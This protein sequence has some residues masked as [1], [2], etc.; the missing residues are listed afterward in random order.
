VRYSL[1]HIASGLLLLAF[2]AGGCNKAKKL[3]ERVTLWRK[4]KIPY[5][6]FYAHENLKRI[7][8]EA[9]I[10]DSRRSPD[11]SQKLTIGSTGEYSGRR[12]SYVVISTKVLANEEELSAM[13]RMVTRGDQVFISSSNISD[14]LLDSLQLKAALYTG[15]FSEH[16]S[17]EVAVRNPETSVQ[18]K[19]FYPG[20]AMDNYFSAVDSTITTVLGTDDQGR[21]NFIK[22]SYEGGGAF[23]IHLAPLALSNFFLLHKDNKSYYDQVLSYLPKNTEVIRWDDYFRSSDGN[24]S[25]NDNSSNFSALSWWGKQQGLGAAMWLLLLLLIIIYLVESKRKQRIIPVIPALNNAS[26]DFVKTIGQLYFQRKDNKDLAYK[27]MVHFQGYV[28]NRYAIRGAAMDDE[29]VQRLAYKSGYDKE[30]IQALVYDLHYAQAQP[31]ITDHALLELNHKLET[32]YKH[33]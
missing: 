7:F 28:R 21:A 8:P 3:N 20:K 17:L 15:F 19:Y 33:A 4:D 24:R 22:I 31:Q 5:G 16:D 32:F 29:F 10:V 6:A 9:E 13:F 1:L 14:N 30:A 27:M 23:Y 25:D 2:M 18:S 26:L 11:Q 12:T